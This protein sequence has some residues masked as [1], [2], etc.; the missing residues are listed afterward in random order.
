MALERQ[1]GFVGSIDNYLHDDMTQQNEMVAMQVEVHN[2][3]GNT[4]SFV[5]K[6]PVRDGFDNDPLDRANI[7]AND[8]VLLAPVDT[9][10][11]SAAQTGNRNFL[12]GGQKVSEA[13]LFGP[14]SR[15]ASVTSRKREGHDMVEFLVR[16]LTDRPA[17]E[18][19]IAIGQQFTMFY[20]TMETP[21]VRS[22]RA[23]R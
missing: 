22:L 19:G 13:R 6:P 10:L 12:D 3:N 4:I 21:L 2:S 15:L 8:I 14:G 16:F 11:A 18:N 17:G 9:D 23:L 5:G 20:I 7:D 1:G